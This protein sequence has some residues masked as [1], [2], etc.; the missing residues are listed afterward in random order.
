MRNK[1]NATIAA[2]ITLIVLVVALWLI[3]RN[4]GSPVGHPLNT[5]APR[6]RQSWDIQ[7]LVVPVFI[8]AGVI[9]LAVEVGVVWMV[10][11]FRRHKDDVDGVG[12]PT[13]TH[14]NTPLEIGWTIVPALILAVLAVFNV[15]T[16]LKLDDT[17]KNAIEVNV[18]GQQWWWEYRYDTNKDGAPDIITATQMVIP[19]GRDVNLKI[20]SNDVIHS[21]WIPALNGKK[22]AV[23][24]RTHELVFTAEK[25]GIYQGQCTEYCGLSHGVMR[26]QVK[27]LPPAQY[28]QWVKRMTRK[29]EQPDTK[30]AK[31]GQEIFVGQCA[32]CHQVNGLRPTSTPPY[33]YDDVPNPQY[34]ESVN[35]SLSSKNAPNLTHLMMRQTFAGGL[36]DLY[37]GKGSK[38]VSAVPSGVP[39]TNNLKDWLRDPEA[40]KPM[41]PDN[42]QGMPNLQL[43]EQQID[44]LVAY[45]VTLK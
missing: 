3:V 19:V 5:L 41:D 16:L 12:E 11:R 2:V 27:A 22:D 43:S 30:D 39:D 40:I 6:G 37:L 20:Q 8:V 35:T 13:Q 44:Q 36:L 29:P 42:N 33:A 9:F 21:F 32:R 25:A 15:Q 28:E 18:I 24:G 4:I 17:S 23:P 45:L 26:M 10:V 7:N 34:G 14:G 31:L 1:R 38:E